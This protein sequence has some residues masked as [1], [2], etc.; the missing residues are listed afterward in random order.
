MADSEADKANAPA[1]AN[2]DTRREATGLFKGVDFQVWQTVLAWVRLKTDELL[3]VEGAEDFDVVNGTEGVTV[4]TK[5]TTAPVT[6]RSPVV[7]DA[8]VNF[9]RTK[10]ANPER[11]VRL[12]F[13]TTSGTG[14]EAG[15]STAALEEWTACRAHPDLGRVEELRRFLVDDSTISARIA[16]AAGGDSLRSF[17]TAASAAQV[18]EE[19]IEP[20]SWEWESPDVDGVREEARREI[21]LYGKRVNLLPRDCDRVLPAVFVRVA[22][23]AFQERR[24]LSSEDLVREFDEATR[25]AVPRAELNLLRAEAT[26]FRIAQSDRRSDIGASPDEAESATPPPIKALIDEASKLSREGWYASARAKLQEAA[27]MARE[28]K[29]DWAAMECRID[30]AEN[31]IM[32]QDDLDAARA[33]L[34]GCLRELPPGG[35]LK[36]RQG[37]LGLLAEAELAAGNIEEGKSLYR[38]ACELARRRRDRFSEAHFLNGLAHAEELRGDLGEAHRLLDQSTELSR[39]EYRESPAD[40][41]A[42]TAI[43]L[44]SCFASKAVLLRHEARLAEA[45]SQLV[46]AEPLFEEAGSLDNLGRVRLL[47]AKILF[48]EARWREGLTAVD[49][50]RKS[51]ETIGNAEWECRCLDVMGK[52]FATLGD[53]GRAMASL[54]HAADLAEASEGRVDGAPYLLRLAQLAKQDDQAEAALAFVA[55]A[56]ESATRVSDDSTIAHCLLAQAAVIEGKDSDEKKELLRSAS[57]HLQAALAKC[58][59]KGRRAVYMVRIGEVLGRLGDLY[60]AEQSVRSAL[61]IFEKIGDLSWTGECLG[62]LAGIAREKDSPAEAMASLERVVALCAGKPLHDV[63]AGAL[64]DLGMLRLSH[65]Q[66]AEA[67]QCLDKAKAIAEKHR[68]RHVLD[69]LNESL[70]RLR[71]A[72]Q[73]YSPPERD[74]AD[75]I[76]ELQSWCGRF[77]AARESILPLWYFIHRAELWA[78]CRSQLGLKALICSSDAGA[79][80]QTAAALKGQVDLRVYATGFVMQVERRT[81]VIPWAED[82]LI[83][84]HLKIAGFKR[85]PEPKRA[86][87]LLVEALRDDP[88]IIIPFKDEVEGRLGTRICAFG[89]KMRLPRDISQF[90]LDTPAERL[91]EE[92]M[93]CLPIGEGKKV[94]EL[95]Q[96]MLVAWENGML[97]FF[98]R[99]LPDNDRVTAECDC[100][101]E[102]PSNALGDIARETTVA[103][104]ALWSRLIPCDAARATLSEVAAAFSGLATA[105]ASGQRLKVR[106]FF[107]RFR[108][109][110]REVVH[111]AVVV[112]T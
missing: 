102:V 45:E 63:H 87:E 72:E 103:A 22:H 43:N 95:R 67:R 5:A 78:I 15:R 69:A 42:S 34:Y 53:K 64:H 36:Q 7:V 98:F 65:G 90:M 17:L 107:L 108:A 47:R 60:A 111:P 14:C 97:P 66:I 49:E 25:E 88:Y 74:L 57:T 28:T 62:L 81:D 73:F 94:P 40:R 109:G 55:R 99:R 37:A 96:I 56:R 71:D 80:R 38:E 2:P 4:Q 10:A 9:W 13:V 79:Y 30:I 104:H 85:A 39:V 16:K 18:L 20:V 58:E 70:V 93:V 3:V 101:C 1:L 26:E 84:R 19:L 21:H 92:K 32:A 105:T 31:Q 12:R 46:R 51:F 112:R 100:S 54:E 61:D 75:L 77:P 86:L 110:D 6:L 68:L 33:S 29:A 83:P 106:I 89:R 59:I 35:R 27:G 41:K 24:G 23:T 50:A 44:G 8:L 76:Q 52:F 48:H 91:I 82:V 11:R